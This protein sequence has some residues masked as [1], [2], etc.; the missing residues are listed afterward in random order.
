[1][2]EATDH[3]SRITDHHGAAAAGKGYSHR[4]RRQVVLFTSLLALSAAFLLSLSAAQEKAPVVVLTIN[5]A[6]GPATA[7]YFHRG[8]AHAV[9]QGAQ[10]VVL[11]M[12]TP[13]GLDTSMRA[14]IKDILASPIPVAAYV[15]PSGARA[16]SAG[17]Y[18]TYASHIAAMAPATNLGAATP[19]Q[20]GGMPGQPDKKP[21]GTGEPEEKGKGKEGKRQQGEPDADP[22]H[23]KVVADASAYIRGLAELRGRNVEWAEKAVREAVSLP[24]EEALKINVVDLIA[25]D[26]SDLLKKVDGKAFD[27]LGVKRTLS[28]ASAAVVRIDPDWRSRL[29]AVIT[30]PSFAYILMLIGIYGLLFEFYSPGLIL[31]GVVGAICL[32]VALYAFQMLPINYAGLALIAIGI[33]FMVAEL[34]V[35]SYGAL[36]VGGAVAFLIG[37]VMLI[38]TDV[39][40]YEIPWSIIATVM[41]TSFAFFFFVIGMALQARRRPV[42]TGGEQLIGASGEI[43]DHA[44][45]QWW[46]RVHSETWRVRGEAHLRRGQ[47]VRVTARDGLTLIVETESQQ[48]EG[49]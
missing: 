26:L 25:T 29:L 2:I 1:V 7:D 6:I 41:A 42:V 36:G 35:T 46:A 47:R 27:L 22:M 37:S 8:L 12:D 3:R 4:M 38:D 34:F 16:A 17:T 11:Q 23:R 44:E 39:P 20:I 45:G 49:E 21:Q 28:T 5:G 31:P 18:L 33:T 15:A 13:G 40:G 43:V 32:L 19:V 10:L 9:D 14:M 30:D 24:A 48:A